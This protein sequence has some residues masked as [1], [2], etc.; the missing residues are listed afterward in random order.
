MLSRLHD[1]LNKRYTQTIKKENFIENYLKAYF[2]D[3]LKGGKEQTTFFKNIKTNTREGTSPFDKFVESLRATQASN[4]KVKKGAVERFKKTSLK[5]FK[6]SIEKS[7]EYKII[8]NLLHELDDFKNDLF[9]KLEKANEQRQK[10]VKN[11][12]KSVEENKKAKFSEYD[13]FTSC[14]NLCLTLRRLRTLTIQYAKDVVSILDTMKKWEFGC[15]I[16]FSTIMNDFQ[17]FVKQ[18]SAVEASFLNE[19]LKILQM[20]IF[21]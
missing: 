21:F 1:F 13:C 10:F 18:N 9:D 8:K 11:F 16:E 3:F 2:D 4:Q 7:K 15:N 6:K 5:K 20:V 14:K 17:I 19:A 12:H